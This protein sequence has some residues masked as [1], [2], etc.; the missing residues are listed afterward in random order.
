M[1]VAHAAL[2]VFVLSI[3]VVESYTSERD[4]AMAVGDT[5]QVG[6]YEYRFE[7]IAPVEG[8]NY[9][10]VRAQIAVYRDG[11]QVGLLH[12]EKRQYWVQRSVMTE[13][14]IDTQFGRDIFAALGEDLGAGRW[15][16]RAQIRPLIN[17][18]W[19]A[20]G[21]MALG[22]LIA[23][24]DRRYRSAASRASDGVGVGAAGLAGAAAAV[25]NPLAVRSTATE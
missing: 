9:D 15:S 11:R 22:G 24:F 1:S 8:P 4:L 3:A 23:A 13:A 14:G 16:V 12:P 6:D 25:T 2:G 17:Y 18:V 5:A 20:A 21:L 19:L 10:G 7:S